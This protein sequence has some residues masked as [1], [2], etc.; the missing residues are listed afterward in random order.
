MWR[1]RLSFAAEAPT[2]LRSKAAISKK[3]AAPTS[4]AVG[5]TS[6]P[7]VRAQARLAHGEHTTADEH[8]AEQPSH[9]PHRAER[10]E[11]T[12]RARDVPVEDLAR[13]SHERV[14]PVRVPQPPGAVHDRERHDVQGRDAPR[15]PEQRGHA[16]DDHHRDRNTRAHEREQTRRRRPS[17]SRRS[18][19][20]SWSTSKRCT[21]PNTSAPVN[22]IWN[23]HSTSWAPAPNSTNTEAAI[24]AVHGRTPARRMM[25]RSSTA[26]EEVQARSPLR[27]R[28]GSCAGR[29]PATARGTRRSAPRP[30]ARSA[31]GGGRGR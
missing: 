26:D 31:S 17:Q 30:S 22:V 23:A 27:R 20:P 8:R 28:A 1:Y 24:V 6:D 7:R 10:A 19:G 4:N 16:D 13:R 18:T 21:R 25:I 9:P 11:D 2:P 29:R 12:R 3:A 5:R 15:P 14:L